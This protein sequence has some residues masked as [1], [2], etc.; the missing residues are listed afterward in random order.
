MQIT[1]MKSRLHS[2]QATGHSQGQG[3]GAPKKKKEKSDVRPYLPA[4]FEIFEVFRSG[5]RKYF[6]GL[7]CFWAPH[8]EKRPKTRLKKIDGKRRKEK[9][10][11]SSTF[12]AKSF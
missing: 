12:S 7:W 3:Q 8:A 5:F 1:A 4:S 2:A 9:S 11:F 10:F 6:Y